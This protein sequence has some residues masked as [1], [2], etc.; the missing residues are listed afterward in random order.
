[1][2]I[3]FSNGVRRAIIFLA[4]FALFAALQIGKEFFLPLVLAI[5]ISFLLAPLIRKME[6]WG[7]GR[8]WAVLV[9]TVL[10]V[11]MIGGLGYLVTGQLLDLANKLPNYKT[12]LSKKLEAFKT[13]PDSPV[14]RLTETVE[15]LADDLSKPAGAPVPPTPTTQEELAEKL[16]APSEPGAESDRQKRKREAVPVEVVA[17]EGHALDFLKGVL[18]PILAPL[19]MAA[20]VIVF[21][22]FM[23][24]EREDLRDRCIHLMGR[25]QLHLTTTALDDA[26]A[27]VSRYLLAQ[28]IVNV[29]YGIPVG[30]GLY[31]IGIPNAFLWGFL[32]TVLRFIPYL[33]PWLAATFPLTLSLAVSPS[34]MVPLATAALFIVLELISNNVVEPW[35]YGSSTGLS[36]MAIIVSAVFWTWVWGTPGLLLATPLTVCIAVLGKYIP[37]L[38]FLDTLLGEKPPIATSDRLYQRLLADDEEEMVTILEEDIASGSR[39]SVYDEVVVPTLIQIEAD[40]RSGVL[41]EE[42]RRE[43]HQQLRRVLDEIIEAKAAGTPPETPQVLCFPASNESDELAAMML[44]GLLEERG[45]QV[46]NP[47]AKS[48]TSEL[49]E[50]AGEVKAPIIC[51]STVLPASAMP[52][53]HLARRLRARLPEAKI[54]VGLW[55]AADQETAKRQERFERLDVG[56]LTS[57]EKAAAEIALLAGCAP[58]KPAEGEESPPVFATAATTRIVS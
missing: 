48:L 16:M 24:I 13:E 58:A 2:P 38:S 57:L 25:G 19:A 33:G 53:L 40:H 6:R 46:R 4:L 41:R 20:L 1:M 55:H 9:A 56:I 34:W 49:V 44:T 3:E 14:G 45:V 30:V 12:N 26:G 35:L 50:L 36:P 7:M 15:E 23:L 8:I 28:L 32:A 31:F 17:T 43:M 11:A 37:S 5:L 21:V 10:A 42:D 18:A 52:A 54:F 22:I 29:T 51:I 39:A 27:R 47:S